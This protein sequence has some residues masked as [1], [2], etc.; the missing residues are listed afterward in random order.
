M[1]Y[2]KFALEFIAGGGALAAI[3]VK[4][5]RMAGTFEQ[6]SDQQSK[7]LLEL[8]VSIEKLEE[9]VTTVAVQK[10]VMENLQ[11]QITMLTKWYD[12]LRHGR[13]LIRNGEHAS[14]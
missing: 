4:M 13:G 6:V 12:E 2:G 8:K 9:V 14:D 11:S 3:L 5:G 10:V 7:E 1:D